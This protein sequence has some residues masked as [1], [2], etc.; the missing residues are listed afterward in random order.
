MSTGRPAAEASPRRRRARWAWAVGLALIAVSAAVAH[1]VAVRNGLAR[2]HEAA[3]HR[4][5][6][7]QTSLDAGLARFEFLPSLLEMNPDVARLLNAQDDALLRDQV[8]RYLSGINATAG[9]STLYV[10]DHRG[11]GMASSDWNEA[12]NPVGTDLAFRPYVQQ[13]LAQ[14]RGRFFGI[15]ATSGRPGYYLS[16]GLY[17]ASGQRGVAVVK[18][19]LDDQERAWTQLPGVVLLLDERG[20][21]ILSTRPDWKYRPLVPLSRAAVADIG[22][23]RPY[24]SADLLALDWR[25]LEALAPDAEVV[26]LAGS[27]YLATR[28]AMPATGWQLMVLDDTVPVQA[29]ARNLALTAALAAAVLCLLG[30]AMWQRRRAIRYKLANQA[31]LQQAHDSLEAK[32][33]QRT[34][35]LRAMQGELIQAGKMAALGQMSAGM[36]HELNQPLA[37]LRT[38]S[39]NACVMLDRASHPHEGVRGNLQRIAQLV[40]RLGRLTYQLKV[41]AHKPETRAVPVMVQQVVAG[42]QFLLS[43][44]LRECGVEVNVQLQPATLCVLADE[45]RLEQVLVN[46]MG[47]AIDAMGGS[48]VRR[49]NVEGREG[50]AGTC[51]ISVSDTGPG[52]RADILPRLFEPFASSKPVGS[53]L[54]LGLM[55]SANIVREFGGSL[56]AVQEPDAG[57]CFVIELP[58]AIPLGGS[59]RE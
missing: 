59:P 12:S 58:S 10:L 43:H 30:V 44:R 6:L 23:A 26:A 56:R 55:I 42:A 49:L 17:R 15:G 36:V 25:P 9:S 7:V 1:Q 34:A 54:G 39:D 27:Q 28:R 3:Q 20:V 51:I 2:A 16:Y 47:N 33:V 8:N 45:A 29:A 11:V 18:V 4:L 21:V 48:A 57:A 52:I 40:D 31:A 50:G 32:V 19:S 14:G 5:D 53:G 22:V 13:A 41:F 46:L 37:A 35:E 24:G 38:L